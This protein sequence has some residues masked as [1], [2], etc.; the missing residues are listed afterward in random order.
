MKKST[1]KYARNTWTDE[2]G[3]DEYNELLSECSMQ[4]QLPKEL[5]QKRHQWRCKFC[6]EIFKS[7]PSLN[8]HRYRGCPKIGRRLKMYPMVGKGKRDVVKHACS[9]KGFTIAAI[10]EGTEWEL[11]SMPQMNVELHGSLVSFPAGSKG[12]KQG[13]LEGPMGLIQACAAI[14]EGTEWELASMPQ[15]NV[16]SH[17]SLVSFPAGSKGHEQGV[18]EGPMDFIQACA[19][20]DEKWKWSPLYL[21]LRDFSLLSTHLPRPWKHTTEEWDS[22]LKFSEEW[23]ATGL[24]CNTCARAI[25]RALAHTWRIHFGNY[26][27]PVDLNKLPDQLENLSQEKEFCN[28]LSRVQRVLRRPFVYETEEDRILA[29]DIASFK[30]TSETPG[31]Q[32]VIKRVCNYF[33]SIAHEA[34]DD[35]MKLHPQFAKEMWVAGHL[36]CDREPLIDMW[37]HTLSDVFSNVCTYPDHMNRLSF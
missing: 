37:K 7:K 28:N 6:T 25:V 14:P 34:M 11:A 15:M 33:V 10:P 13:V 23:E 9:Q 12:H 27:A 22:V 3:D 29:N 36:E 18:M 21:F 17:G 30:A 4:C 26:I 24:E 31:H 20:E 19:A 35:I 2:Y 5:G 1:L 8:Y 16:E 32:E